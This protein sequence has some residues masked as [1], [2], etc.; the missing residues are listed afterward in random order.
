MSDSEFGLPA[1]TLACVRSILAA[2]PKVES[3][4]LYGSRAKGTYKPGSDIDLTLTGDGLG[5]DELS[6]IAGE[7]DD[8]PIP[9]LVDLSIRDQIDNPNLIE[10]IQRVGRVFYRR[11]AAF[12]P[13]EVV[14]EDGAG[15]TSR[16]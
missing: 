14:I 16:P 7:L 2:C 13:E 12:P 4:I 6:R 10:H 11:T 1:S 15:Q 3:A 8:S 9:Y 5:Y